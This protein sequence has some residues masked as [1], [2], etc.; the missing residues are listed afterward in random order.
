M[1]TMT[2]KRG[3]PS[4]SSGRSQSA[5]DSVDWRRGKL[6]HRSA[7]LTPSWIRMEGWTIRPRHERE[8]I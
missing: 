6:V 5:W 4:S 7:C 3:A 2:E 1:R 8:L